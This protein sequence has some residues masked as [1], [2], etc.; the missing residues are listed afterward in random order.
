MIEIREFLKSMDREVNTRFSGTNRIIQWFRNNF[1]QS[2][3]PDTLSHLYLNTD[4]HNSWANLG[5][6]KNTAEYSSAC[7]E[8]ARQ[9]GSDAGLDSWHKV[10]DLGFGCGDQI[11]VWCKDFGVSSENIT[12]INSSKLQ[13][14]F[15]EKKLTELGLSAYLICSDL[16]TLSKMQSSERDRILCLDS[17]YFFPDQQKAYKECFRILRP[18]GILA[19]AQLIYNDQKL[20]VWK[21][22][23]RILICIIARIPSKSRMTSEEL[24]SM[25]K[26][27][28]YSIQK[29]ERIEKE[30][31]SGFS[32]FLKINLPL[33]KGKIPPGL[34]NRYSSFG[35]FLGSELC[36]EFF[37]FVVFCAKKD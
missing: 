6:W 23:L 35:E 17:A 21:S 37:Q 22:L 12:A 31:F 4:P 14:H 34:A 25:L 8:L 30:V 19:S 27:E 36:A 15:A 11:L 24:S 16:R 1:F 18:G 33:L 20:S 5:Y 28:G 26:A 29:L 2:E 10:L 32:N 13:Y 9:L 3:S 7:R